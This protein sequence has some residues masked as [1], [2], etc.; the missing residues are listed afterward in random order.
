[1][2]TIDLWYIQAEAD[3]IDILNTWR[4]GL[5]FT[6]SINIGELVVVS[7]DQRRGRLV[8]G[9]GFV[10]WLKREGYLQIT[11]E[12]FIQ[13]IL[14]K[15]VETPIFDDSPEYLIKLLNGLQQY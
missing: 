1:M 15:T 11:T 13:C 5:G 14:G 4:S 7:G 10:F 8:G 6:R 12:Q 9:G 2:K 3:N